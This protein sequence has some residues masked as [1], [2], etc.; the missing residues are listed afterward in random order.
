[1]R[2]FADKVDPVYTRK[3]TVDNYA[4]FDTKLRW[5]N[6]GKKRMFGRGNQR[7]CFKLL[8]TQMRMSSRQLNTTGLEIGKKC[9]LKI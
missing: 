9:G 1:M 4:K 2:G 6:G 8:N 7:C 3:R 5:K